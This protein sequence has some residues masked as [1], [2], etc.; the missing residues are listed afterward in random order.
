M[1]ADYCVFFYCCDVDYSAMSWVGMTLTGSERPCLNGLLPGALEVCFFALGGRWWRMLRWDWA[2]RSFRRPRRTS[3]T[4][5]KK[6]RFPR[7]TIRPQIIALAL[8]WRW[9]LFSRHSRLF[10]VKVGHALATDSLVDDPFESSRVLGGM[11]HAGGEG[12]GGGGGWEFVY[13]IDCD[14]ELG[15]GIASLEAVRHPGRESLVGGGGARRRTGETG[16]ANEEHGKNRWRCGDWRTESN[17]NA[18]SGCRLLKIAM[19]TVGQ[20]VELWLAR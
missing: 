18:E 2:W 6:L 19:R 15:G 9:R 8:M 13:G 12:G 4:R 17:R 20:R 3:P 14:S 7:M 10:T 5:T 1:G 16:E 11:L